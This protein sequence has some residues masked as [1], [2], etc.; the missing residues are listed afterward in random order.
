[1]IVYHK[2]LG[3]SDCGLRC[4]SLESGEDEDSSK[5]APL[6]EVMETTS[7]RFERW[8]Y[9]NDRLIPLKNP[10][11]DSSVYRLPVQTSINFAE[12]LSRTG[13]NTD[14]LQSASGNPTSHGS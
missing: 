13:S 12:Y 14:R 8:K 5:G 9:L 2:K 3:T 1:M 7:R 11:L 10:L 6:I 4:P